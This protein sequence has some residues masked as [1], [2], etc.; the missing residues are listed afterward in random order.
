MA[1]EHFCTQG[2]QPARDRAL[3]QI[4][5]GDAVALVQQH[6]GNAAHAGTTDTDKVDVANGVF[7][8]FCPFTRD[9]QAATTAATASVFSICFALLAI[10][11]NC[12]RVAV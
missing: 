8:A 7:H 5:A 2:H 11:I 3:P 1:N 6:L 4:A 12:D 10:S 9:S